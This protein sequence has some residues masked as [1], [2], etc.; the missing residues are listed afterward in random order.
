[1]KELRRTL[2]RASVAL[3]C[4]AILSA[5]SSGGDGGDDLPIIPAPGF[6]ASCTDAAGAPGAASVT[7]QCSSQNGIDITVGFLVT[8][9]PAGEEVVSASLDVSFNPAVATFVQGSCLPGAALGSPGDLLV[10]CS[11]VPGNPGELLVTVSRTGQA[12]GV[13]VTGTDVLVTVVFRVGTVGTSSMTFLSPNVEN[14]SALFRRGA[15]FPEVIPGITF[16]SS[17]TLEGT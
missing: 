14:G 2:L 16:S 7:T 12:A 4:A 17:T 6:V 10:I 13:S 8:D 3:L 11:T 1:M 5:C 9:T 15:V